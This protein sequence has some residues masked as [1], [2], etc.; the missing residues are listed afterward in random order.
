MEECEGD[1]R[2]D[3]VTETVE[4]RPGGRVWGAPLD[5]GERPRSQRPGRDQA[6]GV[7]CPPLGKGGDCGGPALGSLSCPHLDASHGEAGG[8][9]G[10]SDQPVFRGAL[11]QL[12]QLTDL[13]GLPVLFERVPLG[14][15]FLITCPL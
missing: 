9:R 5:P 1:F 3:D 11:F 14:I 10:R 7:F 13:R 8:G 2:R 12:R 6:S 15:F 4:G